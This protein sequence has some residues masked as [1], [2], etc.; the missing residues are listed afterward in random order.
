MA[1]LHP[2]KKSFEYH[3]RNMYHFLPSLKTTNVAA[4]EM[5]KIESNGAEFW[6]ISCSTFFIDFVED[7][8]VCFEF[9]YV[10][11]YLNRKG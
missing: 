10:V 9:E 11:K 3:R 4:I 2:S 7:V 8:V 1:S 5:K 6:Q